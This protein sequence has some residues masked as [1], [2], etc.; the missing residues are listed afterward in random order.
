MDEEDSLQNPRSFLLG[1][2]T[3]LSPPTFQKDPFSLLQGSVLHTQ[4]PLT[5][6]YRPH[7]K[8]F[9]R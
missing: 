8:G 4:G 5:Q 1:I 7:M 2:M 6:P 3:D 9:Y